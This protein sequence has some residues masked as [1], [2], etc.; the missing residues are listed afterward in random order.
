MLMFLRNPKSE[1][2]HVSIQS[3]RMLRA[4]R[5]CDSK[6][7]RWKPVREKKRL[8]GKKQNIKTN[9]MNNT[10][11]LQEAEPLRNIA[12]KAEQALRSHKSGI[13]SGLYVAVRNYSGAHS[14]RQLKHKLKQK[15]EKYNGL[16]SGETSRGSRCSCPLA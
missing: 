2:L 7:N 15:I 4:A 3:S 14:P 11:T 13:R 12:R 6:H 9:L 5:S 8:L 16:P 10:T 1:S